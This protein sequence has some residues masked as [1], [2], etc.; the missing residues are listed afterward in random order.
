MASRP[1][2]LTLS[3]FCK[4]ELKISLLVYF[5]PFTLNSSWIFIAL[6]VTNFFFSVFSSSWS[7]SCSV[8]V[9][10]LR[11]LSRSSI[12]NSDLF[13]WSFTTPILELNFF[14]SLDLLQHF[15]FFRYGLMN[16]AI[17]FKALHISLYNFITILHIISTDMIKN[18]LKAW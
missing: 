17:N 14:D 1:R 15:N 4:I 3:A 2:S 5:F 10:Y 9:S 11:A 18:D 16:S 6:F 8:P 7:S 12:Y 13:N